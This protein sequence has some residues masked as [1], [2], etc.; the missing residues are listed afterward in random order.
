MTTLDVQTRP[1]IV[2]ITASTDIDAPAA[3]VWA[4]LT[5][6]DDYPRWNPFVRALTGSLVLGERLEVTLQPDGRKATTMKPEVVAVEDGRAF[7]W[8]GR[9]GVPGVLDGRHRF[10]VQPAGA[11]RSRLVQYE[12][13]SGA[14]VPAFRTMLTRDTPKAF[15]AMNE[16]L[17]E[18]VRVGR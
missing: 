16:A 2:E 5:N 1:F 4:V 17:A 18:R 14:L 9:V 7:E 6:T 8:L 11:D 10:E 12:R 3:E 13:L 15:V